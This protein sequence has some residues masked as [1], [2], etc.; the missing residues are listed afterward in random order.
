MHEPRLPHL[1]AADPELADLVEREAE[2]QHD[3][4]RMIPSE[5]YV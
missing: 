5:N 1:H 2:R 4:L 3:K